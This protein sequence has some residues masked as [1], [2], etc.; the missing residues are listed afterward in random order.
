MGGVRL[1]GGSLPMRRFGVI[2]LLISLSV[3]GIY[4]CKSVETTSA[5]LHN[6][7]GSYDKAI[8]MA[9]L[10][11]EKSPE[12]AEA[13]FQ[14][15]IAYS[16]KGEMALSYENFM[17]AAKF[18]PN[19][20][21]LAN[22]NIQSN[23]ARHYNNGLNEFQLSNIEGA[24]KEFE[25]ATQADPRRVKSW[26]NLAKASFSV[27]SEDSVYLQ[28]AFVAADTL[29]NLVEKEDEDYL[30]VLA[31]VGRVK[32]MSG[33]ID[34]SIASFEALIDE[35]PT[36]TGDIEKTGDMFLEKED[37]ENAAKFYEVAIHGY[38]ISGKE[39]FALYNNLGVIFRKLERY[40]KAVNYYQ[41]ALM[42]QPKDQRTA[43]SL[44]VTYYQAEM[45]DEAI[46][47]GEE[48]TTEIAPNDS[49]GW[50]ILSVAYN[51]KG[52]KIKAEETFKK[53]QEV[54]EAQTQ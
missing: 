41:R 49:R 30:N 37:W 13:Y 50:Q 15:G 5:M 46:M 1:K 18:D 54:Q 20:T 45:W 7:S 53:F 43:Y 10:A 21:E 32:A 12:D 23:W 4:G 52:M 16:N 14:L 25:L 29:Q 40:R 51:K 35:K 39:N 34:E 42:V 36:E 28:K 44:L 19:K 9:K 17:N 33:E 47:F 2:F 11:L 48:Y 24:I 27:A 6:Q 26:L 22:N 31:L 3:A 8:E 38:E